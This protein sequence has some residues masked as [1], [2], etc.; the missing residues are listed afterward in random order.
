MSN[1]I[2]AICH[3][4]PIT[5]SELEEL[6]TL[7]KKYGTTIYLSLEESAVLP[8]ED[9]YQLAQ[10]ALAPFRKLRLLYRYV[11]AGII[12]SLDEGDELLIRQGQFFKAAQGT[13][14]ELVTHGYYFREVV[15]YMCHPK[16]AA[17][18]FSVAEV[19]KKLAIAH[20]LDSTLAWQ[21]GILHDIT[22]NQSDDW[23]KK[24]LMHHDPQKLQLY[25]RTWHS[26][27]AAIWL[28]KEMG[29]DNPIIL[30]AIRCHTLGDGNSKYSKILYIADKIEPTRGYDCTRQMDIACRNLTAA[31]D[32]VKEEARIYLLRKEGI[33]V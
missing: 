28:K 17:H 10:K 12:V 13:R 24:Y 21:M 32:I 5:Q 29:I 26:Y 31:R 6:K 18:S 8:Y 22:K 19:C 9:R 16:R 11:P 20:G 23:S 4:D 27:T 30:N 1:K 7:Q 2:I 3:G 15:R 33:H 14:K 25:H